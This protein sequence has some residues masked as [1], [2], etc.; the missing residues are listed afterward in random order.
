MEVG[1]FMNG[2]QLGVVP[3][4]IIGGFIGYFEHRGIS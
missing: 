2:S 4:G 3:L 1:I